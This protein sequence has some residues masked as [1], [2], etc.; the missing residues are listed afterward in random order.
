MSLC[1]LSIGQ[2]WPQFLYPL[3]EKCAQ[4][5]LEGLTALPGTS[6]VGFFF[7]FLLIFCEFHL[8][9]PNSTHFPV[10]PYPLSTLATSKHQKKTN[11]TKPKS[12]HG[13]R[14]V[15]YSTSFC[16]NSFTACKWPLQ[17]VT[18]LL[19]GLW[20]LIHCRYWPL[21]RTPLGYP[22]VALRHGDPPALVLQDRPLMHSAVHG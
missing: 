19:R 20:L 9:H 8:M 1:C 5:A 18:G 6:L 10:S 14:G 22:V 13:N 7:N 15:S 2:A 4:L 16:P 12:H 11:K 3:R 17:R 21:T